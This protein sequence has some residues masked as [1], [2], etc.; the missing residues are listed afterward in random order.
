MWLGSAVVVYRY[1][2]RL[3]PILATLSGAYVDIDD[4]TEQGP[5]A[6]PEND[7]QRAWAELLR[8]AGVDQPQQYTP[9]SAPD[10]PSRAGTTR[11]PSNSYVGCSRTSST[12]PSRR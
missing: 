11:T 9:E 8:R 10:W 7:V 6:M 5:I 4:G 3:D 2:R 12:V 1:R